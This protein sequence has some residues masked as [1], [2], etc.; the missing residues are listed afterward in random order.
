[1]QPSEP[2]FFSLGTIPWRVIQV[3]VRMR[4][5]FLFVAPEFSTVWTYHSLTSQPVE[6][7]SHCQ[8]GSFLLFYYRTDQRSQFLQVP[9]FRL[10]QSFTTKEKDLQ[11]IPPTQRDAV[12]IPKDGTLLNSSLS[13]EDFLTYSCLYWLFQKETSTRPKD[14]GHLSQNLSAVQSGAP[15]NYTRQ[16]NV[17]ARFFV[18]S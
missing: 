12:N 15:R 9:C 7:P 14:P 5:L 1:M 3:A 4:S 16:N 6:G 17:K 11:M 8:M 18:G 10:V 13:K 2:G